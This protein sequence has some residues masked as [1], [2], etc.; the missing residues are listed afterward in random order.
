MERLVIVGIAID[1]MATGK[2]GMK[3]N[4]TRVFLGGRKCLVQ[5]Q[6]ASEL[7]SDNPHFPWANQR[8][9]FIKSSWER[10]CVTTLRKA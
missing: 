9:P 3:C 8:C 6:H 5:Q 2:K 10:Q 7:T 4:A 1:A